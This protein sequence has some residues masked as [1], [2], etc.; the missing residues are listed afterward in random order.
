MAF[1][2]DRVPFFSQV[3]GSHMSCIATVGVL[4]DKDWSKAETAKLSDGSQSCF[5][6]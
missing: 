4:V 6:S 2:L 5:I 1:H 3:R